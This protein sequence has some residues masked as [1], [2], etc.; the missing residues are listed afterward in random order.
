MKPLDIEYFIEIDSARGDRILEGSCKDKIG[1]AQ[2]H[3]ATRRDATRLPPRLRRARLAPRGGRRLHHDVAEGAGPPVPRPPPPPML[4]TPTVSVWPI[5]VLSVRASARISG[6]TSLFGTPSWQDAPHGSK[7]SLGSRLLAR[8]TMLFSSITTR[9]S[10]AH[11]PA[12]HMY[13]CISVYMYNYMY[14]CVLYIYIYIL[15]LYIIYT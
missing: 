2:L 8:P 7:D 6:Q 1:R 10:D 5:R 14:I 3:D 13:I 12:P 15:Y 11:T 9:P 4:R